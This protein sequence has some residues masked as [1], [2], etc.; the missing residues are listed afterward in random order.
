MI[1]V[2]RISTVDVR[3]NNRYSV[4]RT[5]CR[6]KAASVSQISKETELSHTAV[7]AS[8]KDLLSSN[9]ILQAGEGPSSGGRP[10]DLYSLNLDQV[11]TIGVQVTRGEMLA[12][13]VD[14]AGNI[15]T[16]ERQPIEDGSPN[17]VAGLV[18][19]MAE[20]L[21]GEFIRN[22]R[23]I[24]ALGVAV[25]GIVDRRLGSIV[26]DADF[27]WERV[28]FL[29]LL[30]KKTELPVSIIE[31]SNA[32]AIAEREWGKG[33][34]FTNFVFLHFTRGIG[35]GVIQQGRLLEG[36]N[37]SLGEVGHMS[38]NFD[39][40]KCYCG[41]IGCWAQYAST[42]NLIDKLKKKLKKRVLDLKQVVHLVEQRNQD[43]LAEFDRFC[44]Y[45]AIGITNII[46]ILDPQ[47][48]FISGRVKY[49]GEYYL[50]RI[51]DFIFERALPS[52]LE[53]CSIEFS[54]LPEPYPPLLGAAFFSLENRLL[55][56][57]SGFSLFARTQVSKEYA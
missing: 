47:A 57:D 52:H 10:P 30:R 25:L 17:N 15:R 5:I 6:H 40:P 13:V 35:A 28:P 14:L 42:E 56:K 32:S 45:H 34:L 11:F 54:G 23:N 8:I 36:T 9:L 43:V 50:K 49:F 26:Y 29:E 46:N 33:N 22:R 1:S 3:N 51:T 20:K 31:E 41:N 38:I 37:G 21:G 4:F 2:E 27:H 39:E 18:G 12:A 55:G 44:F 7:K 19:Q 16:E 53:R 24:F 48:I